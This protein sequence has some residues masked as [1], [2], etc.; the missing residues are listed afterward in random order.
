MKCCEARP[1]NAR[2]ARVRCSTHGRDDPRVAWNGAR[3]D[4]ASPCP[5]IAALPPHR[6]NTRARPTPR[7]CSTGERSDRIRA[8]QA[9]AHAAGAFGTEARGP[10]RNDAIA[11]AHGIR[12]R[13]PVR[14]HA[15]GCVARSTPA[16]VRGRFRVPAT[17]PRRVRDDLPRQRPRPGALAVSEMTAL[18][19]FC[20]VQNP[21]KLVRNYRA[22][23]V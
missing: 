7:G 4:R 6:G 12:S 1:R 20:K 22:P 16:P 11:M 8:A 18:F 10:P 14:F 17:R 23:V 13:G 5:A 15:R 21:A 9:S 2:L 3:A 19:H